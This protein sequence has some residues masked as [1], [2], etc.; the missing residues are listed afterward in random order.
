[1]TDVHATSYG[2]NAET[3]FGSTL[4]NIAHQAFHLAREDGE[5]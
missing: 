4:I 3:Y 5:N 2:G 1:M